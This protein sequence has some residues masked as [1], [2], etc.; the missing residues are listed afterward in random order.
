MSIKIVTDSTSDLP[1]NT[2]KQYGIEVVPLNIHFGDQVYKDGIDLT[3]EEFFDKLINGPEFPSTSQPSLGEFIDT[4]ERIAEPGDDIISIHL[5]SKLSGTYNSAEQASKQL[6]GKIN[7][8]LVD[9]EQVTI[10]VGLAAISAAK[11]VRDGGT[12]EDAISAC[13]STASRSNF[14][15]LF[16]TLE[17]LSKGGR[18]GKAQSMLGSL[19]K[20]RPLLMLEE[21]LVA[22]YA[23]ARSKKAGLV[24]MEKTIRSLGEAEEVAV[25]YSTDSEDAEVI[26]KNLSDL[27]PSGKEPII[28]KV[29]PVI[30]T[31]AG[32]GL[33]A[34]GLV[35]KK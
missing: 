16:D 20:I 22:P 18:I 9:T 31:H 15:A 27:L 13:M 11:C 7:V 28:L 10:T 19:L 8:H 17:F 14:Y 25:M 29:G 12:I 1:E 21:G 24:K 6:E 32:P 26:A 4:Y 2:A 35:T 34:V 33:V 5:S 23:K 30:G 3:T